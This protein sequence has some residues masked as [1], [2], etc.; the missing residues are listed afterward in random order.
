VTAKRAQARKKRDAG[1]SL[2]GSHAGAWEPGNL[3]GFSV[4]I[5]SHA[6]AWELGN[7]GGF[8]VFKTNE[9]GLNLIG[10]T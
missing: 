4:L 6:G 7:L 2:I 3:G 1:A 5:G 10:V 9:N 8:S